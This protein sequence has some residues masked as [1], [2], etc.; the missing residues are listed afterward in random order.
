MRGEVGEMTSVTSRCTD[1]GGTP[2]HSAD[3]LRMEAGMSGVE[4]TEM[5][6]TMYGVV[7]RIYTRST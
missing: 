1:S 5:D 3:N 6:Q 4:N 2:G 7:F